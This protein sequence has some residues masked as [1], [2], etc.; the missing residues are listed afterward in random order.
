MNSARALS[1]VG[2]MHM[3]CAFYRHLNKD[4]WVPRAKKSASLANDA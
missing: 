4:A 3:P 2:T 1:G